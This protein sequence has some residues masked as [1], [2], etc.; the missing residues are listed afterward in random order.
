MPGYKRPC[1]FCGNLVEENSTTCPFCSRTHPLE[2]VCPYCVAPVQPAWTTCN[3][4][5]KPL[6]V[7]CARCGATIGPD[8]DACEKCH[9]VARYRCPACQA[10]VSLGAKRCDRCGAKLKELWKSHGL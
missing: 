5:G 10:V 3:V 1:R 4:C 7:V 6:S 8:L 9:A 2:M